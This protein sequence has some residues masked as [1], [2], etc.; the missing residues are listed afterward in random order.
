MAVFYALS[1]CQLASATEADG[2][3][4][5]NRPTKLHFYFNI[6]DALDPNVARRDAIVAV[7]GDR[8]VRENFGRDIKLDVSAEEKGFEALA[9]GSPCSGASRKRP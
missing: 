7:P 9:R 6:R 5:K 2:A 3:R 1:C 4:A 8:V